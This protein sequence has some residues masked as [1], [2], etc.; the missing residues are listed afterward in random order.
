LKDRG[1][2]R[3]PLSP[4]VQKLLKELRPLI[5]DDCRFLFPSVRDPDSHMTPDALNVALRRM[6]YVSV[7]VAHGFRQTASVY[8]N[9]SGWDRDV[10]EAQ[11]AHKVDGKTRDAYLHQAQWWLKRVKM[12]KVYSGWLEGLMRP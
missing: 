12:M 7:H 1:E 4:Q 11:L 6:G 5:G 9:E 2:H 8:L 3:V 10:V